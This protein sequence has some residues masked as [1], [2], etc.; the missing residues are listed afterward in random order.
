V[1]LLPPFTLKFTPD[2]PLV[3]DVVKSTS[4]PFTGVLALAK[5]SYA[6]N[7]NVFDAGLR[8]VH[9]CVTLPFTVSVEV[10]DVAKAGPVANPSDTTAKAAASVPK[11]LIIEDFSKSWLWCAAWGRH[12][13]SP[14]PK[15]R[16]LVKSYEKSVD[17][18]SHQPGVYE[19]ID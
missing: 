15:C 11:R 3:H 5:E 19:E 4:L 6:L 8:V 17:D 16:G 2:A 7:V 13:S 10:L 12:A 14:A 18:S 1:Q 9:D